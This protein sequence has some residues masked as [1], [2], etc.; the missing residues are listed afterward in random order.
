MRA[1]KLKSGLSVVEEDDV[2]LVGPAGAAFSS[3]CDGLGEPWNLTLLKVRLNSIPY[4][5]HPFYGFCIE[6]THLRCF[7]IS[8]HSG[9]G[10]L[11]DRRLL[12]VRPS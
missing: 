10:M 7:G 12:C 11:S 9:F 3:Y 5:N 6:P 8:P 1:A 4:S 2:V